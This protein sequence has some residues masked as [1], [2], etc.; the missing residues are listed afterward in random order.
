MRN[1][2]GISTF[3]YAWS[4]RYQC[5]Q[6]ETAYDEKEA[7]PYAWVYVDGKKPQTVLSGKVGSRIY[8]EIFEH[9]PPGAG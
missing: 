9:D 6:I 2:G 1:R 7:L 5:S 8:P 4:E 3:P